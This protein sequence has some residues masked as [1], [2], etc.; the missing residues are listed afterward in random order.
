MFYERGEMTLA[1]R[2]EERAPLFER[3]LV[4][5]ART[6]VSTGLFLLVA[7]GVPGIIL[8][9]GGDVFVALV[10]PQSTA[11]W[12]GAAACWFIGSGIIA[13]ALWRRHLSQMSNATGGRRGDGTSAE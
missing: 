9:N 5:F 13:A 2:N 8:L 6:S 12:Q 1:R 7:I 11:W 10:G 4:W 3:V